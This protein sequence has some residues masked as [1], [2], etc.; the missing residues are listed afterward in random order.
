M[1]EMAF[2]TLTADKESDLVA[3]LSRQC[4]T[5]LLA[6]Q[7]NGDEDYVSSVESFTKDGR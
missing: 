2:G 1:T 7:Q 4:T 5:H 3:T 6:A